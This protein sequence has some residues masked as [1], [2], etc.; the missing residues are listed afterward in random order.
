MVIKDEYDVVVVGA[1]SAA[2]NAA[3]SASENGAKVPG[4][5]K[6]PITSG[7]EIH[8]LQEA[9]QIRISR[10]IYDISNLFRT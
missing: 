3:L 9:F 5:E 2:L 7:E 8:T 4:L 1:G 10:E 6:A